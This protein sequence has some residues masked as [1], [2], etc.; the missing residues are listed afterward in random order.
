MIIGPG[1]RR[2]RSAAVGAL[3]AFG[4]AAAGAVRAEEGRAPEPP[5]T[6]AAPTAEQ[7][8]EIHAV[9]ESLWDAFVPESIKAEYELMGPDEL[10][11]FFKRLETAG[12]QDDLKGF[13]SLAPET[14]AAITALQALPDYADYADWLREQL[15]DMEAAQEAVTPPPVPPVPP[16][17]P[18]KPKDPPP[19]KAGENVP[20]YELWVG[21]VGRR[22]RPPGADE[23]LPVVR[24]AFAAEGVPEALAWLAETESSFNPRARSPAGARGLFQLMP[25]TAKALGL[26]LLPF[27]QRTQP[28]AS[29][30]AAAAYLKKLHERFGDWPLALAAYNGGEGRV[31]R[32]LKARGAKDFAGIAEH[33]PAETRLYVPKVLA[34]VRVRA[35]VAPEELAAPKPAT[36]R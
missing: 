34:T 20:L 6:A 32:T 33:L 9:A 14:R 15:A 1:K 21:R 3:L 2:C 10:L 17:G 23:H 36:A 31:G 25:E 27:D 18:A 28:R 29:A 35:G 12:A 13:A 5:P 16:D 24:E 7:V 22:P 11:A 26:S 4:F 19:P 30:R 8:A